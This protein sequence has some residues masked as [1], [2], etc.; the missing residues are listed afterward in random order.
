MTPRGTLYRLRVP[1]D[2]AALLRGLHPTLKQKIKGALRAIQ[3]DPRAG[4]P[5][6]EELSGLRS[7]RVS[8]FRIVYRIADQDTID[9]IAVGPRKN[10]YE[11]TFRLLQKQPP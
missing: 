1:H 4:K 3:H 2:V 8:R 5:L 10:I 6:R 11:E 7:Y 9:L